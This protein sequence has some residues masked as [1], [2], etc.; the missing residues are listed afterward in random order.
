MQLV[1]INFIYCDTEN[2]IQYYLSK[3]LGL[4]FQF[5]SRFTCYFHWYFCDFLHWLHYKNSRTI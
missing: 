2:F 4:S 5:H 3:F 1:E